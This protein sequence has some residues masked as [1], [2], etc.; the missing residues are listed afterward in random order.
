MEFKNSEKHLLILRT[1]IKLESV[2]IIKKHIVKADFPEQN[3]NTVA[4][5]LFVN[6]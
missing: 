4:M 6:D 1:L 3:Y 5:M 2:E